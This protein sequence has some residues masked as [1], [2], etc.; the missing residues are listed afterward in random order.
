M[1]N[2]KISSNNIFGT[3][4]LIIVESI[5]LIWLFYILYFIENTFIH[6]TIFVIILIIIWKPQSYA[7]INENNK[8]FNY[9]L[10][11]AFFILFTISINLEI[12]ILYEFW[13]WEFNYIY[14][15]IYWIFLYI[16][17]II[18]INYT[19]KKTIWKI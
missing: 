11:L 16:L 9:Y 7:L 5:Q 17:S 19:T 3:N 18:L 2:I 10:L 13:L 14:N 12:Y 8:K 1:K 15:L 6:M 4:K